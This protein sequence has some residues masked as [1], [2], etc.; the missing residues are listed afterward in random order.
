MEPGHLAKIIDDLDEI[1]AELLIAIEI[2]P[3]AATLLAHIGEELSRPLFED[4]PAADI[5][6]SAA[7]PDITELRRRVSSPLLTGTADTQRYIGELAAVAAGVGRIAARLRRARER[8]ANPA[9]SGEAA[10][11]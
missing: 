5:V 2:A 9:P 1:G 8:V 3:K 4:D 6:A 7:V 10:H 11:V